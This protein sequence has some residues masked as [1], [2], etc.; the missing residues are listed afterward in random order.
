MRADAAASSVQTAQELAAARDTWQASSMARG[1][2]M[3]HMAAGN[4]LN[5]KRPAHVI[6]G[7]F[8][9]LRAE[10]TRVLS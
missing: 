5:G 1:Q 2:R 3:R 6:S 10:I 4:K 8:C 7:Y 9:C